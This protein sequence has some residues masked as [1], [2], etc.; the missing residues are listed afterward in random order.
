MSRRNTCTGIKKPLS[1]VL[2]MIGLAIIAYPLAEQLYAWYWQQKL[3]SEW[4][5][6]ELSQLEETVEDDQDSGNTVLSPQGEILGVLR[7]KS[8]DVSLPII[9][10]LNA[11]NLKIGVALLADTAMLEERG[12]SVLAGHRGHSRGRLLN[13]LNEVKLN[14]QVLIETDNGEK[15][16]TVFNKVIVKPQ[17]TQLLAP[18]KDKILTIVTCDPVRH[19][20]HRLVVQAKPAA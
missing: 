13:R 7:I 18:T 11:T 9:E 2:I 17:E 5:A 14:D 6:P 1:V 20:T 12:N 3:L 16:Y 15:A 8:I 19:P 10:G 4:E